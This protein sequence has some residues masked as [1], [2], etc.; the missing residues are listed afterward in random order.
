ML[1]KDNSI[2][3]RLDDDS[4]DAINGS[5]NRLID[6][7]AIDTTGDL[8]NRSIS[9]SNFAAYTQRHRCALCDII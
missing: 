9:G 7:E 2:K 4:I 3:S 8:I 1:H 5:T 6:N